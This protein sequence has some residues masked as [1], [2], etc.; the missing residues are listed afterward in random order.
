MVTIGLYVCGG[1]R[2][3]CSGAVDSLRHCVSPVDT[4]PLRS[5]APSLA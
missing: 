5:L 2:A 3:A 4:A 1:A